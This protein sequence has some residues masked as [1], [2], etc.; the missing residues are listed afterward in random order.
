MPASAEKRVGSLPADCQGCADAMHR[1]HCRRAR[2]AQI[3][4]REQ[5]RV[6]LGSIGAAGGVRRGRTRDPTVP[7]PHARHEVCQVLAGRA[8]HEADRVIRMELPPTSAWRAGGFSSMAFAASIKPSVNSRMR[9]KVRS[10]SRATSSNVAKRSRRARLRL[11]N[12]ATCRSANDTTAPEPESCCAGMSGS[13][14][15]SSEPGSR[16]Y[17]RGNSATVLS[18]SGGLLAGL[19]ALL[20]LCRRTGRCRR[21]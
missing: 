12:A 2:A 10:L 21:V 1:H 5:Q 3:R 11:R 17:W 13:S 15:G 14:S 4:G 8:A 6:L 20:Y 16:R 19:I 9:A 7:S 18:S